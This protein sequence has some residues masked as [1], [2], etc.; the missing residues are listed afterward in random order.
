M[1]SNIHTHTYYCDGKNSPE[2]MVLQAIQEGMPA[3][4][5]SGHSYTPFD[6]FV[7]MTPEHILKYRADI[8][9]LRQQYGDQIHIHMGL[10]DDYDSEDTEYEWD[11]RIGSIHYMEHEG[12]YHSLDHSYASL[13]RCI[14]EAYHG[15]ILNL[16]RDYCEK[17]VV[18]YKKKRP[19]VV[20]HIDLFTKFN[21]DHQYLNESDPQ[22]LLLM[23]DML[24]ELVH[25]GALLEM[26]TGAISR[27]HASAP[28]PSMALLKILKDLNSPLIITTDCHNANYL[29][30]YYKESCLLLQEAGFKSMI[31]MG[32][33]GF[34]ETAI[35]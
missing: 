34:R 27:G 19:D 17:E 4:G 11:Y 14:R 8:V 20:G 1:I 22:Y 9:Q 32:P 7:G 10:E 2:E 31:V 28:Y 33:E 18:M 25:E 15:Q 13:E 30:C 21:R 16:V 12:Y 3:L 24:S 35:L 5:F 6:S 29:S 26:N 23:H